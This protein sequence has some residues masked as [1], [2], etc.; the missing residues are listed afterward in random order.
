MVAWAVLTVVAGALLVGCEPAV[1]EC[2]GNGNGNGT[3][4]KTTREKLIGTWVE[5]DR[6]ND[7]GTTT[8]YGV[9][10][11]LRSDGSMRFRE[12]LS[13][14]AVQEAEGTWSVSGDT[15]TYVITAFGV[16]MTRAREI[17]TLTADTLCLLHEGETI[18]YAKQS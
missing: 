12:E 11:T 10:L 16:V 14:G 15:L 8:N 7:E 9:T 2:D 3:D 5:A 1:C 18:C 6:T 17:T 13:P 4:G